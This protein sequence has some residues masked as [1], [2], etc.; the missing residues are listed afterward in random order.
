MYRGFQ[1]RRLQFF[2]REL[3]QD[4]E[5]TPIAAQPSS[6]AP[7]AR[8]PAPV[9][10]FRSF[11][12]TCSSSGRG[13]LVFGDDKGMV[14][15]LDRALAVTAFQAYDGRVLDVK[16]LKRSNVIA[17]LGIDSGVA[18]ASIKLWRFDLAD[19]RDGASAGAPVC[20]KTIRLF[21]SAA[22]AS[23]PL[24]FALLEDFTQAAVALADGSVLIATAPNLLR[25]RTQTLA[26]VIKVRNAIHD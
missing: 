17:T 22:G 2:E 26:T 25:D 18:D 6:T 15:V 24:R 14:R 11:K 8:A 12:P 7:S 3:M 9:R 4:P 23:E 19:T 16:Q 20:A 10:L 21:A 5:I 1:W 13:S